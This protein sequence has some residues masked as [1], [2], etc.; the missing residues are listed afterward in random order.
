MRAISFV[1]PL[2]Y[3]FYFPPIFFSPPSS[4]SGVIIRAG[5]LSF[6]GTRL[7]F[8]TSSIFSLFPDYPLGSSLSYVD[9]H[10][11]FHELRLQSPAG[12]VP[13][14]IGHTGFGACLKWM[15]STAINHGGTKHQHGPMMS[16]ALPNL[17]SKYPILSR[18]SGIDRWAGGL[19]GEAR[20]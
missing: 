14:M 20:I 15:G 17:C 18:F 19:A 16:C 6:R 8:F 5:D 11:W 13:L 3:P 1:F 7:D 2:L 12:Q 10:V 9:L 4:T